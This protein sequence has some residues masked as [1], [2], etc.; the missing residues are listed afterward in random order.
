MAPFSIDLRQQQQQI[1]TQRMWLLGSFTG[2]LINTGKDLSTDSVSPRLTEVNTICSVLLP[3]T[4]IEG[5]QG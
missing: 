1:I 3:R 4:K 2:K 5:H